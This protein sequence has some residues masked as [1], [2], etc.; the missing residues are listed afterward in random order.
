MKF[1]ANEFHAMK[2]NVLSHNVRILSSNLTAFL[3]NE[4]RRMI[5]KVKKI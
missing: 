2:T 1:M 5:K 4:G 3:N